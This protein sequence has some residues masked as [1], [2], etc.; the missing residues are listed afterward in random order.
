V[1]IK[2]EPKVNRSCI[3][4]YQWWPVSRRRARTSVCCE[5]GK[6][7]SP[8]LDSKESCLRRGYLSP[9]TTNTN[10]TTHHSHHLHLKSS[11]NTHHDTAMNSL[12]SVV[13][14]FIVRLSPSLA[15]PRQ[16][17]NNNTRTSRSAPP[18]RSSTPLHSTSDSPAPSPPLTHT[19]G[20]TS[21]RTPDHSPASSIRSACPPPPT[22]PPLHQPD[23][24]QQIAAWIVG[25]VLGD[26]KYTVYVGLAGTALTF[27]I[28]VPPWPF[29]NK[30]PARWLPAGTTEVKKAE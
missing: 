13:D 23:T 28:V 26:L 22:Y 9:S 11:S 12:Q 14:G 7:T 19:I 2:N 8:Q 20:S 18:T 15:S 4:P 27:L 24:A 29:F 25:F 17:A 3:S 1:A 21:R 16:L 5:T 6:N 30:H 10:D